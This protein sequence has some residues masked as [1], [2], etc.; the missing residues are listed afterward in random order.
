MF[1]G[2]PKKQVSTECNMVES[3]KHSVE[4]EWEESALWAK[5]WQHAWARNALKQYKWMNQTV[6]RRS[7]CWCADPRM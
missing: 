7:P 1:W 2:A 6:P 5:A 3:H 4:A